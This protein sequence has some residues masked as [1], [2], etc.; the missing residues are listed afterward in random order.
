MTAK[1]SECVTIAAIKASSMGLLYL[2]GIMFSEV[3]RMNLATTQRSLKH[4]STPY[5]IVDGIT[6]TIA[7][8]RVVPITVGHTVVAAGI[9]DTL[10]WFKTTSNSKRLRQMVA[11]L[12]NATGCND[13]SSHSLRHAFALNCSINPNVRDMDKIN[14]G[15][16]SAGASGG[17]NTKIN[18]SYG[19]ASI[20]GEGLDNLY[21]A[22]LEIH[23]HLL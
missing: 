21:R 12:A 10:E 9:A 18:M 22:S 5:V 19:A 23:R 17:G 20:E 14:I 6:K 2:T 13:Y 15:G 4:P 1:Q 8:K 16:W 3:Q 7:R 11:M